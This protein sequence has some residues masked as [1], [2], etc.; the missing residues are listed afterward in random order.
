MKRTRKNLPMVKKPD[1][2]KNDATFQ[3]RCKK[4]EL[5]EFARRANA[6]GFSSIASWLLWH[7]RRIVRESEKP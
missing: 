3:F 6:E 4:S 5:E 1:G 2:Q 7:L